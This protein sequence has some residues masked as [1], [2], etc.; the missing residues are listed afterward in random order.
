MRSRIQKKVIVIATASLLFFLGSIALAGSS[1]KHMHLASHD[2]HKAPKSLVKQDKNNRMHYQNNFA[3]QFEELMVEQ[4]SY[5][6]ESRTLFSDLKSKWAAFADEL[7]KEEPE[8][9][10]TQLIQDEILAVN[11]QLTEKRLEHIVAME[12]MALSA[13]PRHRL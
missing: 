13:A 2:A 5:L 12:E 1:F 11:S 8:A 9:G 10:M 7:E 3:L 4:S 6:K